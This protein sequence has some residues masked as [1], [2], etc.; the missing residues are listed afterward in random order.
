LY[1]QKVKSMKKIV[2]LT[3]VLLTFLAFAEAQNCCSKPEGMQ[4]FAFNEKFVAAHEN[5]EPFTF[6]SENGKMISFKAGEKNGNAYAVLSGTKT[7]KVVLVFHEWWGLNDYIKREAE[8]LQKELGNV[9]VYA[10]DLYDGQIAT[11]REKASALM[12]GLKPERATAII[13]GLLATVGKDKKI[14]TIGWC[15]GGSWS[16]Q[17]TLLADKQAACVMYYGFPEK[18]TEKLKK[19]KTDILFIQA[20]QDGFITPA[21]V[22]QFAADLKKL[23]KTITI[24]QYDADHAFANP[25][26]PKYNKAFS[27]EAHKI[28]V[29]FLKKGLGI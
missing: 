6:I 21:L 20:M 15:M 24:K 12:S 5:P 11:D 14:A 25:S 4:Q 17:A 2:F 26:N 27:D 8:T 1:Q 23:H 13:N 29:N 7:D 18:D 10:V 9:D 22:T 3:V 28:A 19:L 16:L